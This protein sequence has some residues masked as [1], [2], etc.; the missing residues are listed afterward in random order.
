MK[1]VNIS[2][3]LSVTFRH[4]IQNGSTYHQLSSA[5]CSHVG[6]VSSARNIFA[7]FRWGHP[8]R[9]ALKYSW[10]IQNSRF[11]TINS[12]FLENDKD[13]TIVTMEPQ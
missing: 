12:L 13:R 2:V 9:G 6:L 4:C 11:S 3:R 10:G 1:Q 7:K 8:L 5:Y